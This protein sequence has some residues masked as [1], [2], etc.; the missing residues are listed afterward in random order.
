MSQWHQWTPG[1]ADLAAA[2][3]VCREFFWLRE[4]RRRKRRWSVCRLGEVA[5]E[6][7]SEKGLWSARRLLEVQEAW[8]RVLPE[9]YE[10][11]TRLESF[12]GG[13]VVITVDS[14][15]T[16]FALGRQAGSDLLERLNEELGTNP[17]GRAVA[18]RRIEYRVGVLADAGREAEAP[19]GQQRASRDAGL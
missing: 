15:S 5:T 18:V 12:R 6:V 11:L 16:K 3:Q 1:A 17:N 10:A 7:M 13:R 8:G 14:A 2:P 4:N 19:R 9:R